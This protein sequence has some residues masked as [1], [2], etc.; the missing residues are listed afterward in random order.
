MSGAQTPALR[1]IQLGRPDVSSALADAVHGPEAIG[2]VDS[3]SPKPPVVK[4]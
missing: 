2:A 4:A 3:H 1:S